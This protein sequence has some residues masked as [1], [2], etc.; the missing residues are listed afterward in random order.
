MCAAMTRDPQQGTLHEEI[1]M[2]SYHD[3]TAHNTVTCKMYMR[4]SNIAHFTDTVVYLCN[5]VNNK[6]AG[7][8]HNAQT[9]V[10][11]V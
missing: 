2:D 10:Q 11:L 9:P 1:K 3:D 7:L 8:P 4:I 6:T 5:A